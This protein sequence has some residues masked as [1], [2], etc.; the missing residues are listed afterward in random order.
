MRE[1]SGEHRVKP[2]GAR[3]AHVATPRHRYIV[4]HPK[5]TTKDIPAAQQSDYF[6]GEMY[7]RLAQALVDQNIVTQSRCNA[8]ESLQTHL[9]YTSEARTVRCAAHTTRMSAQPLYCCDRGFGPDTAHERVC[10]HLCG[11]RWTRC[12]EPLME[13][14]TRDG[15]C[16]RFRA[17]THTSSQ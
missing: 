10:M 15:P 9:F 5:F 2:Q 6:I 12:Q 11:H 7:P 1:G 17:P 16:P 3:V 13:A 4:V 8:F 14:V